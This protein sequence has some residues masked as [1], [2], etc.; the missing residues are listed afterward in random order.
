MGGSGSGDKRS[1][2][3]REAIRDRI[4]GD[5]CWIAF[6]EKLLESGRSSRTVEAT[7]RDLELLGGIMEGVLGTSSGILWE[8]LDRPMAV[9][10]IKRL[11]E[12]GYA[13]SS[14]SRTLSNLRGFFRYLKKNGWISD[15]P[16]R[17]VSGPRIRRVLPAV[18]SEEETRNLVTLPSAKEH[19]EEIPD[20]RDRAILEVF[21]Q[22][23]VRLSE[24]SAIRWGDIDGDVASILIH[25]KGGKERRVPLVG[26]AKEALLGY[27]NRIIRTGSPWAPSRSGLD[28]VFIGT[29]NGMFRP[30]SVYQIGRIVRKRG[31][32]AGL[33]RRVTPHALR[34]SCATH[35]LNHD[36]DLREI[37]VLLGH[38]SIGTTQ[39]YV[40]TSLDELSR[41]LSKARDGDSPP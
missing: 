25:G 32:E 10:F 22:T 27:R 36:T 17:L 12:R 23:G 2:R 37:Q 6:Q 35:L 28:H 31:I 29:V 8:K 26:E 41:K 18:F 33:D 13:P 24:L 38:A 4:S 20:A 21:Y 1:G 39:R 7:S 40:H 3:E 34:H 15:D 30:L 16:F 5:P 14:I 19:R 9:R 11:H